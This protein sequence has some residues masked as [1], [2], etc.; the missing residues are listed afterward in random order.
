M[1]SIAIA[2]E[3]AWLS[4][5]EQNVGGSE[6]ASLFYRWLYVDGTEA[7]HHL[8]EQVP[9]GSTIIE[10]L[11]AHT[12]GYRLWQQ[13]AGALMPD[14]LSGVERVQAGVHLE[15]ALAA[16][17]KQ[18]WKW[19]SLRKVRRYLTHPTVQGWGASLDYELH[20]KGTPP[21]EFKNVDALVF[22][23]QWVADEGEIVMPPLPYVLQLQHQIGV[24]EAEYGWVV[25]CVGGNQ[26]LRGR[27][28]RHEGTQ[29]KIGAAIE[30]FWRGINERVEPVWLAD[31]ESVADTYRYGR[32]GTEADLTADAELPTL[33][34]QYKA[35]KAA[36]DQLETE[37]EYL[38]GAIGARVGE[39]ARAKAMGYSISW[40]IIERKEKVVPERIQKALTYRGAL[41]VKEFV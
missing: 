16:W 1:G 21:V 5:R 4:V 40:P 9:P 26:L 12:T 33:C 2:D 18:K 6:I 27:I 3:A 19:D 8:Y 29:Q 13:K 32:A 36:L 41:T 23:D 10:C 25:C 38:K 39:N 28:E 37:V 7:V 20:E 24:S 11:S 31:Y 22:R 30:A 35:K 14:D 15:P 34:E 17:A